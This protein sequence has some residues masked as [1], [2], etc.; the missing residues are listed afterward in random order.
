MVMPTRTRYDQW[1]GLILQQTLIFP[2]IFSPLNFAGK[3]V[4]INQMQYRRIVC[5][6][7]LACFYPKEVIWV[8]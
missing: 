6:F 8:V 2:H 7:T 5:S 1:T 3:P 4:L